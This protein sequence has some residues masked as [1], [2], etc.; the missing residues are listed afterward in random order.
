MWCIPQVDGDYVARMEDVLDLYAEAPDPKRPVVCFDE[1]PTQLIG[2]VRQPIPAAPG[3]PRALRLRVSP[4]RHRQSVRLPRRPPALAQ[5]QGHRAAHRR[6]TSP[7]ACASSSMSTIPRPSVI[8]VVL[9]NLSTH[10]AGALYEA[11]P[12][13]GGPP[14]PAAAGVPLHAQA[15][16]LAQHGRDRDRRAARPVPRPPHRRA[17]DGSSPRSPPGKSS[18]TR[19]ALASTGCSPPTRPAPKWP[20]PIP[21]PPKSHNHCAAPLGIS[22]D[23]SSSAL[24]YC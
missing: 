22:L 6:T 20:A 11:F 8:R 21:I 17:Q 24:R 7:T 10:T 3:Q 13:A 9:D 23:K 12:R 4:Q 16:Q 15:R 5:G 1:S 18:A 2:E 19:P 14:H